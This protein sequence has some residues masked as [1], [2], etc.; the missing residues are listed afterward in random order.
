MS[1]KKKTVEFNKQTPL[2][3]KNVKQLDTD[4]ILSGVE[5]FEFLLGQYWKQLVIGVSAIAV[6]IVALILII[7][8]IFRTV[9][10]GSKLEETQNQLSQ[11]QEYKQKY[12]D[13]QLE[14][15][16]S[17]NKDHPA[18]LPAKL[19][20]AELYAEQ[21]SY[22]VAYET[23]RDIYLSNSADAFLRV[24]AGLLAPYMLEKDQKIAEAINSFTEIANDANANENQRTEAIF[25]AARLSLKLDK[26]A[27]AERFLAMVNYNQEP[28]TYW[29]AQCAALKLQ[30]ASVPA[31]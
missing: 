17:E 14:K 24:R 30:I 21:K 20:L 16:I 25:A 3:P 29:V 9:S 10:L 7:F 12:E 15:I 27:D 18:A 8:L 5:K 6:I 11:S 22:R 23:L 26:K 2:P 28:K 13:I 4:E 19:R 1:Q 31:K